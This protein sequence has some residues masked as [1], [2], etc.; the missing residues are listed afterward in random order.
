MRRV[1]PVRTSR[2][3]WKIPLFCQHE[4]NEGCNILFL[5][6]IENDYII[7]EN[8]NCKCPKNNTLEKTFVNISNFNIDNPTGHYGP[9]YNSDKKVI[10][11]NSFKIFIYYPLSYVFEVV[12]ETPTL[13]G[14]TLKDLIY[15]IKNLY[16]YIYT[17]EERTA[18]PQIYQLKKLCTNCGNQNLTKY[19]NKIDK[20][21]NDDCSIC[22]SNYEN[23]SE[24]TTPVNLKC[25]HIF[26]DNCIKEWLKKSGTCPICRTNIFECNN[27]NGS[28]IIYYTFTGVVIPIEER[29]QILNRN[30]TYG[31]FGIHSYDFEDLFIQNLFYDNVK[32]QLYIDIISY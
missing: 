27:C 2:D 9:L 11:D 24:E 17:E 13:N 29:G 6:D 7:I 28:G 5:N 1:Y 22:Y 10:A 21:I 32:K 15:S 8:S 12:I 23:C 20:I 25:N 4:C 31:I 26:H 3:R 19:I 16:E 30:Q 18:T 14:F